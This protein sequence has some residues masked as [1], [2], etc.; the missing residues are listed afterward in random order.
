MDLS[1]GLS[2]ENVLAI[3]AQYRNSTHEI[4]RESEI[5]KTLFNFY[6]DN[7]D[8]GFSLAKSQY[9]NAQIGEANTTLDAL[10]RLPSPQ[11]DDPRIDFARSVF[12]ARTGDYKK[13]LTLAERVE[14]RAQQRGA[15]RM[16]AQA[17]TTQCNLQSRLGDAA[18]ARAACDKSRAI[19][20]DV[21]DLAAEAGVWGQIAFQAEDMKS[22]RIA[23]ER[24]IAL[25]KKVESDGGLAWAMTVAGEL[26][27]DSGDYHRALRVQRSLDTLPKD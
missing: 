17:L 2:R 22:R 9:S 20:S 3:E 15:R 7:V 19:F 24:Q 25:L 6:P 1:G 23:N 26:S 18:K 10:Q 13:A 8:Y 4:A 12:A 27:A 16:A 21:G 14:L 5:Y 11:G